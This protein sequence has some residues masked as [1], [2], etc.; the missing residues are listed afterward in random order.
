MAA[1][2]KRATN[3][4]LGK[5]TS[6]GGKATKGKAA[7]AVVSSKPSKSGA[8]S[9]PTK[10]TKQAAAQPTAK[11]AKAS[12]PKAPAVRATAKKPAKPGAKDA[13]PPNKPGVAKAAPKKPLTSSGSAAPGSNL[14]GSTLPEFS[15][16]DHS[17]T[18]VEQKALL[19]EPFV[20]Y[21]YPKDDTPG[22]TKEAC[23]FNAGLAEF[24]SAGV[25][26]IGVSP[27]SVARHTN[28]RNKYGLQFTL[29]SDPDAA[30]ARAL[31]V[32]KMK[33]NYGREYM[34]IERTTF[35][36]DGAGVIRRVW[37]GVRVAGH[38]PDVMAAVRGL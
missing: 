6:S 15:L 28:F 32:Y 30:L 24:E 10:G 18:V 5:S 4:P 26:V 29:L 12:T 23:D 38:V 25:R 35:L 17:G 1:N 2:K 34:G 33:K 7:Q 36:V 3:K 11:A 27:D 22:C 13:L 9:K 31:D 37:R 21:F 8:A 16:A 20:L 14:E 19:G